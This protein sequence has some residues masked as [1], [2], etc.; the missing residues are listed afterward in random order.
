MKVCEFSI[1][2]KHWK[3]YL[4]DFHITDYGYDD[5]E[6]W[7][8]FLIELEAK[9]IA[10]LGDLSEIKQLAME[11]QNKYNW[12]SSNIIKTKTKL[13]PNAT[14]TKIADHGE[15]DQ[16]NLSNADYEDSIACHFFRPLNLSWWH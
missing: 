5:I 14:N 16:S 10:S 7:I 13:K 4:N 1:S 3:K 12:K 11:R 6:K 9:M 2:K 8:D 15:D